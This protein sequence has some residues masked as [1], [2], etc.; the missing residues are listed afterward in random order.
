MLA[1]A[2]G[3]LFEVMS[4]LWSTLVDGKEPTPTQIARFTTMHTYVV[5][6]CVDVVQ[7]VF[8]AAGGTAVYQKGALDRC[9]RD[10]LTMNQHVVGT[11]RTY[12]MAGRLLLGLQPLR[13]LF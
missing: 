11:L 9:L 10:V 12:E 1:S 2:R 8:K 3:Y 6:A 7:L 4:D 5:G 13:W